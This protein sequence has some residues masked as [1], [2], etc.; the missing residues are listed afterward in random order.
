MGRRM[1]QTDT[2]G[3][4]PEM[5]PQQ[6]HD[7][8]FVLSGMEKAQ[9][10]LPHPHMPSKTTWVL[11]IV[12]LHVLA[13]AYLTFVL[14]RAARHRR[15]AEKS[16]EPPRRVNCVYEWASLAVPRRTIFRVPLGTIRA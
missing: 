13:L 9:H 16:R 1:L 2:S 6:H 12:M 4:V 3:L 8:A 10:L 15:S 11:V 7:T 5:R 14:Y